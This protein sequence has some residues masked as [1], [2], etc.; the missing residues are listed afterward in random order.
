M[1]IPLATVIE[2]P[3][4]TG[5]PL[6]VIALLVREELPM[7]ISVLKLPLI[8]LFVSACVPDKVA[9][10]ESIAIVTGDDPLKLPPVNPVPIVNALDNEAVTEIEPPKLTDVPLI[11]M[12]LFA[13][14]ALE[15]VPLRSVVGIVDE[16]VNADVPLPLT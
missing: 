3:K 1:E 14:C 8:D 2:P 5:V 12:A 6:I 16:A 13:N 7:L 11:V 9:T 4:L 15:I 10:V